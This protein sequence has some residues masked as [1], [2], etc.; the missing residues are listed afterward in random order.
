[1]LVIIA[2][3]SY[4]QEVSND[5]KRFEKHYSELTVVFRDNHYVPGQTTYICWQGLFRTIDIVIL[6]FSLIVRRK[7]SQ[8]KIFL[9]MDRL[10]KTKHKESEESVVSEMLIL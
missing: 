6:N 4:L 7:H 8:V 10:I 9:V 2:I 1:M 3:D 5:T